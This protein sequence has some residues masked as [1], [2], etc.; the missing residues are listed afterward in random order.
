MS[1]LLLGKNGQVGTALQKTLINLDNVTAIGRKE[2][3]L[4]DLL[5]LQRFLIFQKPTIIINAAAYT[6]VDKAESNQNIAYLLNHK[7]VALLANY[8]YLHN[9]LL[10]HYST[11]YVFDGL[12]S[13]PY[14][15]TDST[16]PQNIY[17]ASKLAGEQAIIHSRCN[18]LIFRTSWVVSA[19]GKNFV[20]SILKLA[21]ERNSIN[22]VSD[23]FGTPTTADF[24]A[25]ITTMMIRKCQMQTLQN[26]LYHLTP[27]GVTNWH[28]F[29][30]YIIDKALENDIR[31][32]LSSKQIHAISSAEYPLPAQRPKNS[33]LNNQMLSR[34]LEVPFYDWTYY[35]DLL[36]IQFGKHPNLF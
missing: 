12:K 13:T 36:M 23:Q 33:S 15:E 29:S 2:V 9:S 26:G 10:V 18:Y 32:K 5:S 21:R 14:L 28:A 8:A 35:V 3:D 19:I 11:D 31:L 1:I 25:N 30:R 16:N 17:G 7:V 27:S 4:E 20:K 24:I 22:V 6:A 34:L